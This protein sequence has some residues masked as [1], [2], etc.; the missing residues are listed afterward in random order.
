M[1]SRLN[2]ETIANEKLNSDSYNYRPCSYH[3]QRYFGLK[4]KLTVML[5]FCLVRVSAC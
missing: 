2:Y 3:C 4:L 5:A 1:N